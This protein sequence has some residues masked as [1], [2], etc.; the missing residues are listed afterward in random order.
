MIPMSS[1]GTCLPPTPPISHS[2]PLNVLRFSNGKVK[3]ADLGVSRR[4]STETV[5]LQTF[6]GTPLYLAPELVESKPY[7]EK[8]DVWALGVMLYEM[9]CLHPPFSG[10]NIMALMNDILHGDR[11]PVPPKYSPAVGRLIDRMLQQNPRARPSSVA[12]LD[13]AKE[14]MD[15]LNK[16]NVKADPIASDGGQ[17]FVA[18]ATKGDPTPAE[19]EAIM[20]VDF[21][22][23]RRMVEKKQ[24][25]QVQKPAPAPTPAPAP[26]PAVHATPDPAP[27]TREARLRRRQ[28]DYNRRLQAKRM[29]EQQAQAA[30]MKAEPT[31]KPKPVNPAPAQPRPAPRSHYNIFNIPSTPEETPEPV[32]RKIVKTFKIDRDI[33]IKPMTRPDQGQV[34]GELKPVVAGMGP[35]AELEMLRKLLL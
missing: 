24:Q 12:V 4:V 14:Q 25:V 9:A 22:I 20:G 19:V 21:E 1:I 27:T 6:F 3:L 8:V 7:T 11:Q 35:Q 30:A 17:L 5:F 13:A 32:K 31:P 15:K 26:A 33:P 10:N 28:A 23:G 2:K 18:P 34:R 16:L 29:L